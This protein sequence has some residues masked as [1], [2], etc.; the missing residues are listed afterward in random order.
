[1]GVGF[2]VGESE[3]AKMA[4]VQQ[5]QEPMEYINPEII[6]FD[7][8]NPRGESAEQILED[9]SFKELCTSVRRYGILVPLIARKGRGKA[10][11]FK[12]VDGERR[13]RA[14]HKENLAKVPVHIIPGT[15]EDGRVLAYNVHMLR[16][17]WN[18]RIETNAIKEIRDKIV[19]EKPDITEAELF[20]ELL[21]ITA[22]KSHELKTVL[23]LLKYDNAAVEKVQDGSLAMS[24]LVQI[25]QSFLAPMKREFPIIYNKYGDAP[26]RVTL[27]KKAEDGKL[28]NTRYL[29]E[30]VAKCF[31]NE[32]KAKLR[33]AVKRFLGDADLHVDSIVNSLK[34][35]K[36]KEPTTSKKKKKKKKA[37]KKPNHEA[38]GTF[39]YSSIRITKTHL[40]KINDIRPKLE[41]IAKTFSGEES[42]YIKEAVCCLENHCFKA[43]ALM[44]WASGMSRILKYV[45]KRLADFNRCSREMA[46]DPKSFYRYFSKTFQKSATD[47]NDVRENSNDRQLLCYI[48]Y[49]NMINGTEFKKLKNN[50]D[51][52]NDC[53][54]PTSIKLSPNEIVVIFENVYSLLLNSGNLK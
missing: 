28:G 20:N 43:A 1:M 13:L 32:N 46:D 14:A 50:Y 36:A 54:H 34:A 5:T 48:C 33:D 23:T 3:M 2:S 45:E 17:Q 39:A 22:H 19:K 8:K 51:T 4:A 10:K 18:K 40:S 16:K 38:K 12:L 42:E 52:R 7:D 15:E 35:A 27:V 6:S 49:K 11:R 31:R 9:S 24:H 37:A 41:A 21:E 44:I 29:M 25:D 26:L 47:I 30:R 53:A